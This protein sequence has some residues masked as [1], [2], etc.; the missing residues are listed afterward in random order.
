MDLCANFEPRLALQYN[1]YRKE[2]IL[3]K[4]RHVWKHMSATV[5][6]SGDGVETKRN[7]GTTRELSLVDFA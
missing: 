5:V 3:L 6:G 1:R 7:F 4:V 2:P